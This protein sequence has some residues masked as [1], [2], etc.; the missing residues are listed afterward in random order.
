MN[1]PVQRVAQLNQDMGS[2]R[3]SPYVHEALV[4]RCVSDQVL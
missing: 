2:A 4:L 3:R 1:D